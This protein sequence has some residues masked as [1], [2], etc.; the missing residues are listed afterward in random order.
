MRDIQSVTTFSDLNSL[1]SLR[2]TAQYLCDK[3]NGNEF[4]H[5]VNGDFRSCMYFD[6]KNVMYVSP[7]EIKCTDA[8]NCKYAGKRPGCDSKEGHTECGTSINGSVPEGEIPE[9]LLEKLRRVIPA[10]H[11]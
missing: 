5:L 3:P 11:V 10:C 6:E 7:T 1:S 4:C 9:G 8:R 2:C